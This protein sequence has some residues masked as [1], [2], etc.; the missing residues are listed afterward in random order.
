MSDHTIHLIG[1]NENE[2]ASLST[3]QV[4][5][6]CRVVIR[7]RNRIM[8]ADG[9]DYFEAFCQLRL[10]LKAERLIP[11]CYGA[12][13]NVYPSGMSRSMGSG[14]RAYRLTPKKQTNAAD[15]VHIFNS[16]A[17]VIPASVANQ[18]EFFTDWLKSLKA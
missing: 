3:E 17:D 4:D 8:E 16:G 5:K 13:L 10:R 12:S 15:L 1:G 14:L 6:R 7:Y 11:F 18:K 2:T 9:S